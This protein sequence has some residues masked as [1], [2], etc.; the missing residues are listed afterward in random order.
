MTIKAPEEVRADPATNEDGR[1]RAAVPLT[2]APSGD[3]TAVGVTGE[4]PVPA[5][6]ETVGKPPAGDGPANDKPE[7]TI[8]AVEPTTDK[9]KG[10]PL[11]DPQPAGLTDDIPISAA[12]L[13][14]CM[15]SA[16]YWV[17]ALPTYADRMQALADRWALAAGGLAILTGLAVWTKL[18]ES[19]SL[20]AETVV[21]VAAILA[22]VFALVPRIKNYGELAGSAR[23]LG[24][25]AKHHYGELLDLWSDKDD[26][27]SSEVAKERVRNFEAVRK[28]K[29]RLRYL[30]IPSGS[31]TWTDEGPV[32]N[33]TNVNNDVKR[34]ST[35]FPGWHRSS[36][37]E[38]QAGPARKGTP[39]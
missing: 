14:K 12:R 3:D 34:A 38:E 31:P 30:P 23:E 20:W 22:G 18:A 11:A 17:I 27:L 28:D 8:P 13:R 33:V 37:D 4:V 16:S 5:D 24:A 29:D 1:L 25:Q 9:P 6:S 26:R 39:V 2:P 32:W 21:A 15:A 35:L 7:I 19:A 36:K 10:N